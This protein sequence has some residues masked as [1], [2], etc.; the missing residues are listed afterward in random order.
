VLRSCTE[1]ACLGHHK[2]LP[3]GNKAQMGK[4]WQVGVWTR[5]VSASYR[6]LSR[7]DGIELHDYPHQ[8]LSVP[9]LM[10]AALPYSARSCGKTGSRGRLVALAIRLLVALLLV[11]CSTDRVLS[12]W[13][14][15]FSSQT[16]SVELRD[17]GGSGT[18][19]RCLR[20]CQYCTAYQWTM[21]Q[22]RAVELGPLQGRWDTFWD[23]T[24]TSVSVDWVSMGIAL[25]TATPSPCPKSNH[26]ICR[27][28][29]RAM[30]CADFRRRE[31]TVCAG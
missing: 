5:K 23:F 4:W 13:R 16:A 18:E 7:K 19:A 2:L 8:S 17:A 6:D 25:C 10:Q 11:F 26:H 20:G 28:P 31:K 3:C 15:G 30:P 14:R 9:T 27:C 22:K 21:Q 29:R 1:G 12:D 24:P